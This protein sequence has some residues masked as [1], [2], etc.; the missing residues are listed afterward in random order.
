MKNE[1][2]PI[3][4]EAMLLSR[5]KMGLFRGTSYILRY[6]HLGGMCMKPN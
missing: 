3:V 5:N 4:M 2:L 6:M 1:Q